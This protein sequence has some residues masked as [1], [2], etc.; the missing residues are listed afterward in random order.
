M[1]LFINLLK[2]VQL[3]YYKLTFFLQITRS[4]NKWKLYFKD[5]IMSLNGY[6]Y[7]FQKAT[8]DAEW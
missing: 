1:N 5:G 7:V 6:D 2:P 3:S 4:R 8:G